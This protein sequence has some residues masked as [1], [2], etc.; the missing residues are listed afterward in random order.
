MIACRKRLIVVGGGPVGCEIAQS[1]RRLGAEV[2]PI[3]VALLPNEEPDA[4]P[5]LASVFA[6]EGIEWVRGRATDA[7]HSGDVFTL[8]TSAGEVRG[9]MLLTATGRAPFVQGLGLERAGVRYTGQGIKTDADLRTSARNIYAAG[10]VLGG[11]QYSHLAGWQGFRR[12]ATPCY[13]ERAWVLHALCHES[14]LRLLKW[15]ALG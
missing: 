10:D 1:Y 14:P 5:V 13:P 2:S 9:D 6:E 11:P 4:A 7:S 3:A 15:P 12:R 8:T